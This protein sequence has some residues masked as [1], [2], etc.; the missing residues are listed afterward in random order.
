MGGN[1][2]HP[3]P[4]LYQNFGKRRLPPRL[5]PPDPARTKGA[6][7]RVQ[8]PARVKIVVIEDQVMMRGLIVRVCREHFPGEPVHDASDTRTG[9]DLC[10][11]IQP[12]I[13]LLDLDLPDGDGLDL[14]AEIH[15]D[16]PQSK[17]I[18]VTSHSDEYAIHRSLEAGV[19]AFVDKCSQPIEVVSEAIAA[20]AAGRAYFS[21]VV[22]R[23]KNRL[24]DDPK[25]FTKLLSP[26]EQEI[27]RL[28]G[29]GLP[30]DQVAER[31][32]VSPKTIHSYRRNIMVK[33]GI[34]STPQLIRYA[35]EKGFTRLKAGSS[36]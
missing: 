33:L 5:T 24:R 13:V 31:V 35:M 7:Q 2:A 30:N 10:R 15:R 8:P 18:V 21:P 36:A 19:A 11:R 20:V 29:E 32:G 25:A 22:V 23:A 1:T 14:L 17:I 26:R 16:S 9:V 28:L 27:L 34:H 12:D 3:K 6:S 4:A